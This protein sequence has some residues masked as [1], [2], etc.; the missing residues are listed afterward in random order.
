MER[1]LTRL[2]L[3]IR[4]ENPIDADRIIMTIRNDKKVCGGA[5]QF[6]L[7]EGIG[8]PVVRGDIPESLVRETFQTL[9]P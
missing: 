5:A 1:L 9:L 2:G 4:L 7:L 3:A 6:V 8:R